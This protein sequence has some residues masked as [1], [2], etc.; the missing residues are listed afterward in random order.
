[1]LHSLRSH[2]EVPLA[3]AEDAKDLMSSIEGCQKVYVVE[4]PAFPVPFHVSLGN[5]RKVLEVMEHQN[6]T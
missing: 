5:L 2:D 4:R 1:V 6:V 3:F